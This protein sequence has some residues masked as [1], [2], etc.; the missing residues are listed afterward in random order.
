MTREF[1]CL[2][3]IDGSG[4]TTQ[5]RSLVDR[6]NRGG[7]PARYVWCRWQPFFMKPFQ[8]VGRALLQRRGVSPEHYQEFTA[9]KQRLLRGRFLAHLWLSA[10]LLDYWIVQVFPKIILGK[11]NG[12]CLVCDRY[13]YDT[14]IDQSINLRLSAENG[15]RLLSHPLV[16]I[17][18]RPTCTILIDLDP[19]IAFDRKNDVDDVDYLRDRRHRYFCFAQQLGAVVVDGNASPENVVEEVNAAVKVP[20][21]PQGR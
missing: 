20:I 9:S 13:L 4:K 16:R 10:S 1:I 2:M 17:F 21:S 18:P 7:T 19:E 12:K 11:V 14:L 3:G 15:P 8:L 5:A 6:L